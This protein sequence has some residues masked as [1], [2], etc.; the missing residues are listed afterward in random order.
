MDHF[1][2]L[3][4]ET[5]PNHAYSIKH[6]LRYCSLMKCFMTTGSLPRGMEI[7]EAPTMGDAAPFLRE[8][9]V[10]M[11]YGRHPSPEKHH[12]LD[13][14]WGTRKCKVTN[15]FLYINKCKNMC[16]YLCTSHMHQKQKKRG[17]RNSRWVA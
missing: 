7:D 10:M 6:K 14:G 11:V 16:V 1:K 2:K 13:Q 4:E 17:E 8:D 12:A 3:L 5:C 15:F 9:M